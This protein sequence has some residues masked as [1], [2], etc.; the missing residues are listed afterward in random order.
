MFLQKVATLGVMGVAM[1]IMGASP[2]TSIG[3]AYAT[4][5]LGVLSTLG[6]DFPARFGFTTPGLVFELVIH[7]VA[8]GL[9]LNNFKGCHQIVS[10]IASFGLVNSIFGLFLPVRFAGVWGLTKKDGMRVQQLTRNVAS[11]IC[12]S[13]LTTLL[14][15]LRAKEDNNAANNIVVLGSIALAIWQVCKKFFTMRLLTS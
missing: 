7:V 11:A 3:L 5:A 14:I 4:G 8:A 13:C 10:G 12:A 9:L 6:Q 1:S 2:Q 15:L